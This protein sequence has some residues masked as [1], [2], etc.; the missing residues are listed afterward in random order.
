VPQIIGSSSEDRPARPV[1]GGRSL[2]SQERKSIDLSSS[3][4][5][6]GSDLESGKRPGVPRD[7]APDLGVEVLYPDI[8]QQMSCVKIHKSTEHAKLTP[9]FGTSCPPAG[10][11]GPIRDFAYKFSEGRLRTGCC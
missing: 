1:P 2:T 11:S 10:L 4:K 3:I 7:K 8:E 6:W 5:G 9:V